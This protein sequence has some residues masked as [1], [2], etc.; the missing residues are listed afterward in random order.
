MCTNL[1]SWPKLTLDM[2]ERKQTRPDVSC[3]H[4][5]SGTLNFCAI[6]LAYQAY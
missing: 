6:Y 4:V 5:A 1:F 3:S 2:M